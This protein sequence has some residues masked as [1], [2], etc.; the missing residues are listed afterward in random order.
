MAC[1]F[2]GRASACGPTSSAWVLRAQH[3]RIGES[4][5]GFRVRPSPATTDA[6]PA[7]TRG[8]PSH[9]H[10]IVSW[11][12]D[13]I[14][15]LAPWNCLATPPHKGVI[16]AIRG[17]W[18]VR[19]RRC[20]PSRADLHGAGDRAGAV[21]CA[22]CLRGHSATRTDES[23]FGL[24][25]YRSG[26][27][28]TAR[29]YDH[30]WMRIG[31]HLPWVAEHQVSTHWLRHTTLTWVERHFGYAVARAYAGHNGRNDAGV[32]STYVR[33]DVHEVARALSALTG[34]RHPL[35]APVGSAHRLAPLTA[36]PDQVAEAG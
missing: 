21:R 1:A 31:T 20:G 29:R 18:Q 11:V 32:T 28:L 25:R 4:R 26:G 23:H 3:H 5:R 2:L 13:H 8:F 30:L 6:D 34:E 9:E 33:A 24:L 17:D 19:S 35:A 10:K 27:P 14:P 22:R 12:T 16:T 36:I 15:P 7:T